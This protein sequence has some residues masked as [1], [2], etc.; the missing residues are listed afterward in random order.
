MSK[1]RPLLIE[2]ATYMMEFINDKEVSTNFKFTRYPFSEENF[3]EFIKN[4]WNDKCN[5][6]FAIQNEKGEYAGTISLKNI[7]PIDRTAEYS[8]VVRRKFWGCGIAKEATENILDYG[9]RLLNLRKIYLNVLAT[10]KRASKFY[11]KFGFEFE[12][13]FKQHLF[14]SGT[15]VNLNWYCKFNDK[16]N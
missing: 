15:F 14:V 5:I 12:G 3:K 16:L 4:S 9:F 7:N 6:H 1:L 10:N 13:T 11:E 2:D 8:I